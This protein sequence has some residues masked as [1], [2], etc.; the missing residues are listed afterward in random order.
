MTSAP[1]G[2]DNRTQRAPAPEDYADAGRWLDDEK[3]EDNPPGPDGKRRILA[4]YGACG[5]V[6]EAM[7]EVRSG[8]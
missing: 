3:I 6:M 1:L 4:R 2:G 7:W 8:K 5:E